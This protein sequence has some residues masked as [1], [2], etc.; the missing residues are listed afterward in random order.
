MEKRCCEILKSPK[1]GE[2]I[3]FGIVGVVATII[4]YGTYLLLKQRINI[5]VSYSL[6][7]LISLVAN[8]WLS[9]KFTF[10]TKP[11]VKKG[12]GFGLSHL[13]NYLLHISFLH[14][15]ICLGISNSIAPIPV[16]LIVVPI[17]FLL[18]RTALRRM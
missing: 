13:I 10:R 6:G 7:Y 14:L 18:V 11:T 1:V 4:H 5:S 8:F 16:F 2:I 3:R 12:L 9:N 15:F 17:N